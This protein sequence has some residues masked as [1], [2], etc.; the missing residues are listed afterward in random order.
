MTYV[1]NWDSAV[2]HRY[3]PNISI[4]SKVLAAISRSMKSLVAKPL[5]LSLQTGYVRNGSSKS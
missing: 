3:K 4:G 1:R 2:G 5:H